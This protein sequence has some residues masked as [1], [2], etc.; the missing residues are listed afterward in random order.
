[1]TA[2]G[3]EVRRPGRDRGVVFQQGSLFTWMTVEENI[4][5]GP[6]CQGLARPAAREI[7]HRYMRLVGLQRFARR[8]PYA[9]RR[10]TGPRRRTRS[11]KPDPRV[12]P[13]PDP[14]LVPPCRPGSA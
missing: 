12:L 7:A 2:G 3:R 9:Y 14:R 8:Y 6:E 13:R 1:M 4:L 10:P 5:F 11:T